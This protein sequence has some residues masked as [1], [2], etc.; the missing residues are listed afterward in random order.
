[1]VA[2]EITFDGIT[3]VWEVEGVKRK[4]CSER[5][6]DPL[7]DPQEVAMSAESG[8]SPI[9]GLEIHKRAD[10]GGIVLMECKGKLIL[11]TAAH[12]K[13]TVSKII[14]HEKRI[15]LDFGG[16]TRM[17]SSGLGAL[18]GLYATAQKANCELKLVNINRPVREV[19]GVTNLL[20]LF[21]DVGE[22]ARSA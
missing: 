15:T 11:E 10:A 2:R 5:V 13:E 21:E 9:K 1:M 20:S 19:L 12:L 22:S 18:V 3:C 6:A 4:Q 8:T 7:G 17:D 14:P 16:V